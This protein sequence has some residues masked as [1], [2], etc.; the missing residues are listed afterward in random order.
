ML[1]RINTRDNSYRW[2]DGV[3][4]GTG[5]PRVL[6]LNNMTKIYNW[7]AMG[8]AYGN[9]LNTGT[10]KGWWGV[11]NHENDQGIL[12]IAS[13]NGANRYVKGDSLAAYIELWDGVSKAFRTSRSIAAGGD[14]DFTDQYIPTM[15]LANVTK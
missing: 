4:A 7:M 9:N 14:L 1:F 8:I 15:D 6:I 2:M 11:V 10:Q 13:P 5:T 12:R 3:E